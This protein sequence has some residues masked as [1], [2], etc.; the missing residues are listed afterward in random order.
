[1]QNNNPT[2]HYAQEMGMKLSIH[3]IHLIGIGGAGMGGIAEV[4]HNQGFNVTGSDSGDNAMTQRLKK[5]G[6]TVYQ[7]HD[8]RH[9]EGAEV[10]V[11]SS[12]VAEDNVEVVYAHAHKIPVVMR[13][14]MLAELMRF[15]H[16]IAIAGT[17]GK[18][19]TTSLAASVLAEAGL[20]PTFVIGGLLNSAG[21]NARLGKGQFFVVEADESDASFLLLTPILAVVTNIDMDHMETYAGDFQR[22]QEAFLQFIHHLPFYGAAILC[23]DDPIIAQLLPQISRRM[24]TYGIDSAA[25]VRAVDIAQHGVQTE[26]TVLRKGKAP[27]ALQLNLAGRHNVLNALSIVALAEILNIDDASLTRAFA[28]FQGIGRRFQIYGEYKPKLDVSVLVVDDYG[29]HPREV[30]ATLAAARAAWPERRLVLAYQPHRYTRTRDLL[31]DF[32]EVLSSVD[33]LL[34]LEIYAAGEEPIA[35]I[36]SRALARA[37]RERG[38]VEPILVGEIAQLSELLGSVL[39]QNDVL[40]TQGAGSIGGVAKMLLSQTTEV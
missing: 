2:L 11:R 22:L 19:T 26:F 32:A 8:A 9:V 39:K 16:G 5:L 23:L 4:L 33:V 1:V 36:N 15:H 40:L 34:L 14:Q 28:E 12:A 30:A 7:G 24:V 18:T 10:V 27:L 35:G 31:D 20:D 21:T 25:D 3:R 38:K 17:H 37:I 13:A 29:H 6:I